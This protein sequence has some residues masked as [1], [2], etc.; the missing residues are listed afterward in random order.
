[1]K[2]RQRKVHSKLTGNPE[3]TD[4]QGCYQR[5]QWMLKKFDNTGWQQTEK[6]HFVKLN[7]YNRTAET[8]K[9]DRIQRRMDDIREDLIRKSTF[10]FGHC[11][12]RGVYPCPNFLALFS[13][14]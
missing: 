11:P 2:L 4:V 3:K 9:I 13:P 7:F 14:S 6:L 10:S 5:G 12:K 8:L 1:M